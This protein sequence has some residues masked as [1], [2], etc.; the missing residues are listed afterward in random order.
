M[1]PL[2]KQAVLRKEPRVGRFLCDRRAGN[3][4]FGRASASR[5]PVAYHSSKRRAV[6]GQGVIGTMRRIGKDRGPH[7]LY[8]TVPLRRLA[9][10][11]VLR[12]IA[13]TRRIQKRQRA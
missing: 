1:R 3:K 12:W 6:C 8:A 10:K 7:G 9:N 4:S 13:C 5:W 11:A 2:K